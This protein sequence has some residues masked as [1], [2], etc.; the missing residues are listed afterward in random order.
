MA[1]DEWDDRDIAS[2]SEALDAELDKI[3]RETRG[4]LADSPLAEREP[5]L[6]DTIPEAEILPDDDDL[7]DDLDDDDYDHP[8]AFILD[9]DD[10]DDDDDA[11]SDLTLPGPI[12]RE[13]LA[14]IIETAVERGILSALK[15]LGKI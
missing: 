13:E 1:K 7:A 2:A 3:F 15:K 12:S 10:D 4:V 6:E 11:D 5:A 14:A 8:E 9:D